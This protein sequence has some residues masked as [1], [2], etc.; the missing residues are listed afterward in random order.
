MISCKGWDGSEYELVAWVLTTDA[1]GLVWSMS[2]A[3]QS[4]LSSYNELQADCLAVVLISTVA[5]R[6]STT[7]ERAS[8]T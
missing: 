4:A 2:S 3:K 8:P 7:S 5:P 1:G 6:G